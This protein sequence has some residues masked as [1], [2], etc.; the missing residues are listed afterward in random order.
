[1]NWSF[2]EIGSREVKQNPE[3]LE[4]F[5]SDALRSATDALIR[6]D[7]QNR[8]DAHDQSENPVEVHYRFVE[9]GIH[10][11]DKWFSG[12]QK[13]L[14]AP[15]TRELI[16]SPDDRLDLPVPHLVIEDFNTTGLKGDPLTHRDP[17]KDSKPRND[18]YW[19][20]RN[21]G[22]SGKAEGDR[23]RWGLGKIV[24]PAS[25]EIRS[26]FA[27]SITDD[28]Q[29]PSLIGRSVLCIH[30]PD[31]V[32]DC[33]P[34]GFFSHYDETLDMD[35]PST[36]STKL[37]DFTKSFQLNR[38]S[39][40]TGLS[41][42]IPFPKKDIT[43]QN[44]LY[45]L[46]DHWLWVL[47]EGSLAVRIFTS[48]G[49]EIVITK[50]TIE[51]IIDHHFNDEDRDRFRRKVSFIKEVIDSEGTQ[52]ESIDLDFKNAAIPKYSDVALKL[53]DDVNALR[54]K[55]NSG[56][57]LHFKFNLKVHKKGAPPTSGHFDLYLKRSE[58]SHPANDMALREGL[59]ISEQSRI[60]IPGVSALL[61]LGNNPLGTL[62]GDS[63][64][65]AH[66]KWNIWGMNHKYHDGCK[67]VKFV[68]HASQEI[69]SMLT[70]VD[71]GLDHSLLES[72]FNIPNPNKKPRP[73][74]GKKGRKKAPPSIPE[75]KTKNYYLSCDRISGG[76]KVSPH[77]K[78]NKPF[79]G[80]TIRAAYEV[81]RGNAFKKHNEADFSFKDFKK[82]GLE[83]NF[84]GLK[85]LKM[86][87]GR[88]EAYL[89]E[90][91]FSFSI[92][93]FDTHRDLIIDVKPIHSNGTDDD[94]NQEPQ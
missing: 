38:Q 13:H 71:Q 94:P 18:F 76:F 40:Q 52:R 83:L 19:F 61:Y 62:L 78:G 73:S 63:E 54:E 34:D 90:E 48:E 49:K 72:F 31:G 10:F 7:I 8:L 17:P 26:F 33:A 59:T 42:I 32:K 50:D 23:G 92:T 12:I 85:E 39:G 89:R 77:K 57:L 41:L 66:T 29:A 53:G 80:F 87:E 81:D 58:V 15:E 9:N 47:T 75:P 56:E 68:S 35:L 24:Y 16:D 5:K 79:E 44:L 91:D 30:S 51:T 60:N 4:F 36:D 67:T 20:I 3:Y 86:E 21:V 64:N 82:S 70:R 43:H 1:M 11:G 74:P 46:I 65:P 45:S 2:R 37:N 14:Q 28:T 55:Y 84:A 93:G 22:R 6:E 69:L 27:L 25:S 88:I